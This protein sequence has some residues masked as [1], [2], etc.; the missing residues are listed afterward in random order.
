MP[1]KETIVRSAHE[2]FGRGDLDGFLTASVQDAFWV[3]T[4]GPDSREREAP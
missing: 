2:A 3:T 1:D 4:D